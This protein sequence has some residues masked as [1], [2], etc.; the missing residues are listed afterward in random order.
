MAGHLPKQPSEFEKIEGAEIAIIA[1]MWHRQ[2]IDGMVNRAVA[3]LRKLGCKPVQVHYLPGSY[4]LPLAAQFLFER[5][6]TL[7]AIIA[8][9]VIL[10]GGTT[11][12]LTILHEIT[13]GFSKVMHET[14]KPIINEVIGVTD[15]GDAVKRSGDTDANKGLEA[16]FAASELLSWRRKV[17][18]GH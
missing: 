15:I 7:D 16:A 14:G 5:Q 10:K 1:S 6:P 9:G 3:E 18:S 17:A 11:H 2:C 8:F 12:D 4:E 13:S